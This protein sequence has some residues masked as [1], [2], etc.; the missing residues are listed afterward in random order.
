VSPDVAEQMAKPMI[1]HRSK[2]YAK[3]HEETVDNLKEVFCTD[4]TIFLGTSSSTGL[5]EAAVRNCVQEKSLHIANG[6]FGERW[7]KIAKSNG[8]DACKLDFEWGSAARPEDVE[9]EIESGDYEALFLT[10]NETSTAVMTPMEGFGELCRENDMLFCVDAVSSAAGVDIDVDE[11]GIDVLVTGTQK[12]FA[13]APGLSMTVV[14]DEALDKCEDVDDRGYY[15]DYMNLLKKAKKD[16]TLTTPPIPQIRALNYQLDKILNVEGLEERYKRHEELAEYSREWV[17]KHWEMFSE[18]WCASNTVTCAKNTRDVDL[19]ELGDR[20]LEEGYSFAN[21][22]G[23]LKG[24][25]F[26]IAHMGDR[27]LEE[28]KEYLDTIEDILD[29]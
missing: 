17:K 24:D 25:A 12:A 9:E 2:A 22:Y 13:V 19:F 5:M 1:G 3:L 28:L 18:D 20:L 26:R 10:H 27:K 11:L 29:L 8:K 4:N 15:F 21:G 23:K 16:N 7:Y 14:S 6:A